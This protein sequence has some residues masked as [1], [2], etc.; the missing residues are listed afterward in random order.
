M[1]KKLS[2]AKKVVVLAETISKAEKLLK[3]IEG[4]GVAIELPALREMAT[5]LGVV[6]E[7]LAALHRAQEEARAVF[8]ERGFDYSKMYAF[9][10]ASRF[11]KLVVKR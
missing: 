6:K 11:V 3:E 10:I 5:R 7:R 4:D 1:S 9:E 2:Y 8:S